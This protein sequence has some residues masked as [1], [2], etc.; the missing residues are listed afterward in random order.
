VKTDHGW[1]LKRGGYLNAPSITVNGKPLLPLAA[2][3]Q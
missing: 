2:K 3:K 1:L